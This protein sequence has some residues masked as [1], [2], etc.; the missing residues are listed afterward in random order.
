MFNS[1]LINTALKLLTKEKKNISIN[2]TNKK[3]IKKSLSD[4]NFDIQKSIQK[5]DLNINKISNKKNLNNLSNLKNKNKN[6]LAKPNN[7]VT[8]NYYSDNNQNKDF[9]QISKNVINNTPCF[10]RENK[11]I[12]NEK[13]KRKYKK[14]NF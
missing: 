5:E 8:S 2:D 12:S 3:K 6:N 7:I 14:L 1:T 9:K 10:N 13:S 11:I 4:S